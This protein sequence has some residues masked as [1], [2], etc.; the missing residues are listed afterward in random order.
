M[1]NGCMEEEN[2]SF[3]RLDEGMKQH[4]K[5][6]FI[7]SKV[8]EVGGNKVLIDGG[9]AMNLMPYFMLKRIGMFD[10]DLRPHNMVLSNHEGNMSYYFGV[11]QVNIVVG[12]ITRPTLFVV[13]TSKANY[14]L[15]LG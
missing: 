4:L 7:R 15:F 10:T 3:E 6:I 5:P 12:T 11:I 1:N 8:D 9:V 2:A 13:I 14:N